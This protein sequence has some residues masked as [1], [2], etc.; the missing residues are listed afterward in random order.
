MKIPI[1]T[2]FLEA[3]LRATFF[4]SLGIEVMKMLIVFLLWCVLW[5]LCWPL[6]LVVMV[7][8]PLVW[9]VCLP[10]RCL[11]WGFRIFWL[12]FSSFVS[13]SGRLLGVRS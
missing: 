9:L 8:V 3:I 10:F 7:A 11:Y 2:L 1:P 5:V 6:A 13:F 4:M 12:V